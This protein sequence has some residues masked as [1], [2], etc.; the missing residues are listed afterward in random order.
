MGPLF[1][2]ALLAVV[3]FVATLATLVVA[4][5]FLPIRS[6]VMIALIFVGAGVVGCALGTLVQL[7]FL[8]GDLDSTFAVVRFL[9]IIGST[10]VACSVLAAALFLRLRRVV[11]S[12]YRARTDARQFV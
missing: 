10:G 9:G 6:A 4:K 11:L 5:F 1:A 7:P 12:R 8:H 3:G 2:L